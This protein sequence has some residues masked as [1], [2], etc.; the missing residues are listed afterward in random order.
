MAIATEKEVKRPDMAAII[1]SFTKYSRPSTTQI[2]EMISYI[3]YLEGGIN[4]P[5]KEPDKC[6]MCGAKVLERET[7]YACDKC[8]WFKDK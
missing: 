6:P 5:A 3:F 2:R 8:E 1:D 7:Y 4:R